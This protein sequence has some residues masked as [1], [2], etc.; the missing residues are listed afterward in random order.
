MPLGTD[1]HVSKQKVKKLNMDSGFNP[2]DLGGLTNAHLQEIGDPYCSK[3]LALAQAEL[4][5][6]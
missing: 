3:T 2:F 1:D 4:L 5:R 6:K